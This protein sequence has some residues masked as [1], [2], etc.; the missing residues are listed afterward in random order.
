LNFAISEKV[1]IPLKAMFCWNKA[2]DSLK[3]LV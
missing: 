1:I 3:R 2:F